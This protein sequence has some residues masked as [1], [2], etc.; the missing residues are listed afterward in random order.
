VVCGLLLALYNYARFGGVA[1]FGERY[2]LAG[3][4]QTKAHFY[5]LSYLLPGLFTYLLLPARV[6]LA[7]PH[8]F[9]Q[10]AASDPFALPAGYAGGPSLAA[11]P[12]GGVFTTM[13]ITLLLVAVAPLWR[14]HRGGERGAVV[15]ATGLAI[16]GL[17]IA[18]LVSWALF[19]TTERY[20]VDFVSFLLIPSFLVWALLLARARSRTAAR[21]LWAVAGVTLTFIGAA[22]GIAIS[23]TGYT[24]LLQ[25]EHPQ[26]FNALQDVAS[27]FATVA[28]MIGGNPQIAQIDDGPLPV[29]PANGK[30]DFSEDHASAYLG[31]LPMA[32]TVLSPGDR[33][34]AMFV[35]VTPGPGA[36]PLSS[37]AI[38]VSGNGRSAITP[39][40]GRVARL[41][42]SLHWGLNRIRLTIAGTPTSATE[43]LLSN[44][45]F[46]S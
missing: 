22:I 41:P 8:V 46:G 30:I 24:N 25:T 16:L 39:L 28:T 13:P 37:V 6:V 33:R 20:E 19:G 40:I 36:P 1:D 11:E 44:I 42:V 12:T 3:I 43:V 34:A 26:T 7:F 9:L 14:W 15:A 32:L 5:S 27:P 29:I 45:E 21:R 18:A 35:T 17:S 10:T 23:L 38:K 31:S 4:D 2:E